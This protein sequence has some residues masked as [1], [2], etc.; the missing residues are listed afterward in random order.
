M[1]S[2]TRQLRALDREARIW[3]KLEG[4]GKY[5]QAFR[6]EREEEIVNEAVETEPTQDL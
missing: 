4:V 5:A 2:E 3:G 1:I 6:A